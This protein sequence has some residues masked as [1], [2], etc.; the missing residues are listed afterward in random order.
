MDWQARVDELLFDGESVRE[1]VDA[2]TDLVVV[3][4]HR[5]LAFTPDGEGANVRALDRPNVTGVEADTHGNA[6]RLRQAGVAGVGGFGCLALGLLLDLDTLVPTGGVDVAGSRAVGIGGL[7]ETIETLL[8]LFALLD[9]LLVVVGLVAMLAGVA[10]GGVY[11]TRREPGVT[12]AVAGDDDVRLSWAG[13]NELSEGGIDGADSSE[14]EA[15]ADRLRRA[16]C[17]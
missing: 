3:T 2:G 4:T 5:V 13:D 11:W 1:R 12:I 15:A 6:D 8:G 7:L 17:S 14:A 16:L 10:A 9:D